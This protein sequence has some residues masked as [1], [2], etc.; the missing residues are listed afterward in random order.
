[1]NFKV[2]LPYLLVMAVVTYSIRVLPLVLVKQKIKNRFF[3]SILYY[4]PYTVLSAMTIPA[5][6]YATNS[7]ISAIAGLIVAIVLAYNRKSLIVVAV[8]ACCAVLV[9]EG[10]MGII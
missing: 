7:I 9:T 1:M 3:N 6:F 10:I 4:I 5:I 2:F 8:G